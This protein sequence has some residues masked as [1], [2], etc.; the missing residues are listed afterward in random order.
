M[1]IAKNLVADNKNR[2]FLRFFKQSKV[3]EIITALKRTP[4]W[5]IYSDQEKMRIY[6]TLTKREFTGSLENK[7]QVNQFVNET[8]DDLNDKKREPF[9]NKNGFLKGTL[10]EDGNTWDHTKGQ[11]KL[12]K[13]YGKID[14]ESA[15]ISEDQY[16]MLI[17]TMDIHDI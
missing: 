2:N 8:I 7:A 11:R 13:K 5:D 9:I 17:T 14:I 12:A 3:K 10:N 15:Y 4:R 1:E 16:N 6:H